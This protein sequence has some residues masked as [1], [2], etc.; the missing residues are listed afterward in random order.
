[1]Q[2]LPESLR[3]DL[4]KRTHFWLIQ[5]LT[6]L[7]ALTINVSVR[8]KNNPSGRDRLMLRLVAGTA[9]AAM[10]ALLVIAQAPATR[11]T[12]PARDPNTAGFVTAKELPDSTLP[13]IDT[14]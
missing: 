2:A 3:E 13:P 5:L 6:E 8:R 12:P 14:D 4:I 10:L 11:P 9:L 1:M 7:Q